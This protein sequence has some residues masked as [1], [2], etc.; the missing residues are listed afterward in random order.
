MARRSRWVALY[1]VG[2]LLGGLVIGVPAA[3]AF[4]YPGSSPSIYMDTVST[5]TVFDLGCSF[6]TARAN[7]SA[8]QDSLVV[9]DFGQ[10]QLRSGVYGTYDF[11]NHYRTVTQIRT[12]VVAYAHGFY[13]CTGA[14]FTAHV[15]I[16]IGTSNFA[17]FCVSCG[18]TAAEVTGHGKAWAD[19]VDATASDIVAAGYASQVSVAG[20]ADIEV[21]WGTSSIGRRWVDA[22]D[23]VNSWPIYDYGDA[24][25]CRQ[26][27]TTATAAQCGSSSWFQDDLYWIAWGSP[28]AVA[29]PEI[30]TASGSMAQQWQQISLWG[31][32]AGKSKIL[33]SGAMT[34]TVGNTSTTGWTQ[35]RDECASNAS[36]ALA[37]LAFATKIS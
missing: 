25:G 30:Y 33:F 23:S 13:Q 32:K 4:S 9:L 29:L 20:A 19:M 1:A 18:M 28:S 34:T 3:V 36:T 24:A 35:L 22:Y 11:S 6:G 26:S 10:V 2:A 27:G 37:G 31:V 12:A 14:N 16:G 17:N 15:Q 8:P 21:S 7:G 5:T